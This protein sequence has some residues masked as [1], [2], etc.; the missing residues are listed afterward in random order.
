A[1][2]RSGSMPK[3]VLYNLNPRDNYLFACLTGAFQDG[4]VPGK[5]QFGSGWWFLDQK[6][7]MEL[8]LDALSA[9]GLLSRFVGMLTDSRS[10]LSFPRHEY[11][12]RILCNIIGTEADREE[13]PDDFDALATLIRAVCFGNARSHFGFDV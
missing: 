9:T 3:I 4:S 10:F 1:L 2:A 5:I 7:G 8:Q 11:F 13:L 6:N 12:R